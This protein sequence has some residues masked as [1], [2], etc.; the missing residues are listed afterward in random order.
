ML[1][2]ARCKTEVGP[3]WSHMLP[4]S[5]L[6]ILPFSLVQS[7]GLVREKGLSQVSEQFLYSKGSLRGLK[8]HC[9]LQG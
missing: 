8:C 1:L 3:R 2:S 4:H 5:K 6:T 7:L 9:W